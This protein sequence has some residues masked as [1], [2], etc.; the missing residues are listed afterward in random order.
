MRWEQVHTKR[1]GGDGELSG[2]VLQLR[3]GAGNRSARVFIILFFVV[4]KGAKNFAA[5]S[6]RLTIALYHAQQYVYNIT[7]QLGGVGVLYPHKRNF[8]AQFLDKT[9]AWK[10]TPDKSAAPA[11]VCSRGR[12]HG[13]GGTSLYL[14]GVCHMFTF[15]VGIII[16][17]GRGG[18]EREN[19]GF[20]RS[21][22]G[23]SGVKPRR[24][25]FHKKTI[26]CGLASIDNN[27]L[28]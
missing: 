8:P 5:L 16:K 19:A 14:A 12:R 2:A 9:G 20:P 26:F 17:S 24:E 13:A 28:L 27:I 10:K 1:R 25:K 18:E 23:F 6:G 21:E 22:R 3:R 15:V 11:R 4:V 7:Q